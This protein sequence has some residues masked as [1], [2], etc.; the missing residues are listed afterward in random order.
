MFCE[1]FAA[2]KKHCRLAAP[3]Q[4][5]C[6]GA[7]MELFFEMQVSMH[8]QLLREGKADLAGQMLVDYF[9]GREERDVPSAGNFG[10]KSV[11]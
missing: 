10:L 8:A 6:G 2:R 7:E 4:M 5:P 11:F 3:P 1:E 9:F